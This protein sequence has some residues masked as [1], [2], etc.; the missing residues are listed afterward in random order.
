MIVLSQSFYKNLKGALAPIFREII[1]QSPSNEKDFEDTY[2]AEIVPIFKKR[3]T[4]EA[5]NC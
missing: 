5:G 2:E 1:Q 3:S 4:S